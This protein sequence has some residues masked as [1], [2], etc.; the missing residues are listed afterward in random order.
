MPSAAI[1]CGSGP[2]TGLNSQAQVRPERKVGTAQGTKTKAWTRRRPRKGRKSSRASQRRR[3]LLLLGQPFL[4]GVGQVLRP[5]VG[6]VL[7]G[8]FAEQRLLR[9]L[10]RENV[11]EIAELFEMDG[12]RGQ[13]VA[14][15]VELGEP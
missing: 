4:L 2:I 12:H 3:L 8:L 15:V 6:D 13:L 10:D 11:I 14:R 1:Q 5:L 9:R 7:G